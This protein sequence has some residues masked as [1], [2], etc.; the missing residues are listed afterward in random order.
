MQVTLAYGREG[1]KVTLPDKNVK[2]LGYKPREPLSDPD[3]TVSKVLNNPNGTKS[4]AELA[5]GK[6]TACI[7]ISDITRP[8]PNKVLLAPILQTLET[9][10]VPREGIVILVGTGLHRPSTPEE[11]IEM[12]GEE[13]ANLYRI[14]DHYAKNLEQHT[15]FG[16]TPN[17]VPI[18]ID[19]RY[20]EAELKIATGL[21]EPH[22][23][24]GF[25][26]GRKAI[27]PGV[28]AAETINVWHSPLF[29]EHEN[30][31][32]GSLDA[33]PVHIENSWIARKVG[34]DFIVNVVLDAE[35]RILKVV[36]GGLE[37][38]YREGVDFARAF[39]NDTV[40][41]PVDIVIT[42]A[43]GYPLDTTWY[44]AIKGVVASRDILKEGGTVIIAAS[45][46]N[47]PG[48]EEFDSIVDNF[49]SMEEFLD[50]IRSG[51][52]FRIDQWQLEQ[53]GKVLTKGNIIVV[54]DGMS[55]KELERHYVQTAKSVED[56]LAQCLEIYGEDAK[57]AVLPEGPY[58]LATLDR[59]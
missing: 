49:A 19:S 7:I 48:S 10:G 1:L 57:I 44:Q 2:L 3:R 50:A 58:V 5:I 24:A 36:A 4:L 21:I 8:V 54:S 29:L 32:A 31:R 46:S 34:C 23:M 22:N 26:G 52:F 40:P 47:G 37:E 39:L 16:E 38:A 18:W 53:L 9:A 51:K 33:N 12:C 43:A 14:E 35:R 13:I 6:K 42:C 20:A 27:C 15:Y 55:R 17:N 41:E 28:C 30:A 56:A 45:L 59:G 25:S 11:K